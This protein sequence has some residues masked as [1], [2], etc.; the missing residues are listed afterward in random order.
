[1]T[2]LKFKRKNLNYVCKCKIRCFITKNHF[3][4]RDTFE[5]FIYTK[6]CQCQFNPFEV[7]FLNSKNMFFSIFLLIAEHECTLSLLDP[8][9]HPSSN[10]RHN[11]SRSPQPEC[12]LGTMFR[13]IIRRG[14]GVRFAFGIVSL[15][16][17]ILACHK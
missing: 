17:G 15:E 11:S 6:L 5:I 14:C 2:I 1:M 7:K 13:T 16:S 12:H 10:F 9:G 8:A 3:T 4:H